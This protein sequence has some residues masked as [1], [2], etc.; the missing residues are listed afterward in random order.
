MN[1]QIQ[2]YGLFILTLLFIFYK[3]SKTLQL[4]SEKVFRRSLYIS[5]ISL[6]LDIL[7]LVGIEFMGTL[8]IVL[9]I[10][11]CKLYIMSLI[12]VAVSALSYIMTDLYNEKKHII[13]TRWLGLLGF[14]QSIVV[15]LLPISIN[16]SPDGYFTYGTSV[17]L[18]YIFAIIHILSIVSV[19]IICRK[20][21]SKRRRFAVGLWVTLW[22]AAAVVQYLNNRLLVVG[23][24][25]A[26]G[27]LIIFIIMEN[28]ESYRDRRTGCFNSYA[29][30]EF[31]HRLFETKSK[32]GLLEI[33]LKGSES[34][35]DDSTESALKKAVSF[36]ASHKELFVFRNVNNIIIISRD[37]ALLKKYGDELLDI[38]DKKGQLNKNR[39]S[40][41]V[42][43]GED[44]IHM[45]ELFQFLSFVN[46]SFTETTDRMYIADEKVINKYRE[47]PLIEQEITN[48]LSENRVEVFLQPIFSNNKQKFTSAEALVRIRKTDG[49]LLPPDAFIPVAESSGQIVRLGERVFEKVCEFLKNTN[50][51][52]LGIHYVEVNLSVVQC[53]MADLSD[54]LIAIIEK[55]GI[56]ANLINLEITESAS[57]TS[58]AVLLKNMQKLIE[59]GFTFS[60]DDFGKGQSNLMYVVEMP[61]SIIKLDYDM[62]KAFFNTPKAK[63]VVRAV[64]SMAHGM[65]LKLVAEGIETKDEIDGMYNENI[66]YIQGYF[67]SKPLPMNE[68]L[69]FIE[70]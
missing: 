57:V 12:W 8:S 41:F 51:V 14:I 60:L 48:A 61:V 9:V 24:A 28:P 15:A 27:M 10:T 30:S 45:T 62:S 4:Y 17:F 47:R 19:I 44:F 33:R 3:T 5:I 35:D 2:S 13:V 20:K 65:N 11:V 21:I 43:H 59:Y 1:I 53:E 26:I 23:F 68:F 6:S 50:A 40:V 69:A 54:R 64:V 16:R 7:S 70:K 46:S 29:L 25:S 42:E 38:L 34:D 55:Y 67:Y 31:S 49:S 37:S 63:Q 58:R 52:E 18:V 39:P 56:N 32:F 66:D 36:A 22:I